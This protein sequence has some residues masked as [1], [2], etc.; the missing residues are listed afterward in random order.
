ME[1]H[2]SVTLNHE[3][4]I[5]IALTQICTDSHHMV[6]CWLRSN[7]TCLMM[8][9]TNHVDKIEE[10]VGVANWHWISTKDNVA[11]DETRDTQYVDISPGS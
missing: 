3:L 11:D 8:F 10:L 4:E 9:V 2:L 7:A 6:L 5:K 1:S